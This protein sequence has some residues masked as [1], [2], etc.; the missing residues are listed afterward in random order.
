MA[1]YGETDFEKGVLYGMTH[2]L[3]KLSAAITAAVG[4]AMSEVNKGPSHFTDGRRYPLQQ[5]QDAVDRAI[6]DLGVETT[7]LT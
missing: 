7:A 6:A 3:P 2:D 5:V 1:A 4:T